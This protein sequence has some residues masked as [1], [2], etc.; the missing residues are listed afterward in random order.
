M[1]DGLEQKENIGNSEY[2]FLSEHNHQPKRLCRIAYIQN[3]ESTSVSET[4]ALVYEYSRAEY[5]CSTSTSSAYNSAVEHLDNS[6]YQCSTSKS[7]VS[8]IDALAYEYSRAE[9]QCGASTSSA[10][11][12]V[13]E[14]LDN[15]NEILHMTTSEKK[16]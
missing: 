11:N 3:C 2:N 5:Q 4:D 15:N 9:Y 7:S 1:S 14:H 13:V 12:P 6:E 8:E 10:Y 16:T